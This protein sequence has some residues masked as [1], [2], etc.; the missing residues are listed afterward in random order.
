MGFRQSLW[1]RQQFHATDGLRDGFVSLVVGIAWWRNGRV[2]LQMV[3]YLDRE[4][5]VRNPS[6]RCGFAVLSDNHRLGSRHA[7][8]GRVM[9]E[10]VTIRVL[11]AGDVSF[12]S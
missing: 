6:H 7:A 8:V 3:R 10:Q 9:A 4:A 5:D 12:V 2:Q 11:L 1:L